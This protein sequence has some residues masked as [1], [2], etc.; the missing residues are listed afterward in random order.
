MSYILDAL[1]R[2]DA[3]RQQGHVPGLHDATTGFAP[4][5]AVGRRALARWA[6][7]AA[8]V[9]LTVGVL[10]LAWWPAPPGRPG[11]VPPQAA[12]RPDAA[13]AA[14]PHATVAA[15]VAPTLAPPSAPALIAPSLPMVVS[16]APA[17]PALVAASAPAAR[18]SAAALEGRAAAAAQPKPVPLDSL[19]ANLRRELPRLQVGGSV[20]S[21]SAA[22]RF[23]I[24]DGQ[25][26]REGESVAA[27]LVLERILP[28]SAV[29]RWREMRLEL[30]L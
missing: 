2:A 19:D 18:T 23:V 27:G 16:A 17:A 22:N 9:A 13:V 4:A 7:L 30:A 26:L 25:M 12:V 1:R 10:L 20:W 21:D 8:A 28:K 14:A 3:E 24:L 11:S 6:A 5:S 15:P 29:L